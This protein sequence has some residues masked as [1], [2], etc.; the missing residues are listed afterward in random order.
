MADL[1]QEYHHLTEA[2]R[3]LFEGRRRLADLSVQIAAMTSHG[4][5]TKL[6]EDLR[7]VFEETLVQ[8]EAHRLIILDVIA[9]GER[10]GR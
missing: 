9:R 2:D 10:S 1:Q 6:A 8:W 7:K 5:D 4:Q 3:H